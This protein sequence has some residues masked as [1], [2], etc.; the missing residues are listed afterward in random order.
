MLDVF[1]GNMLDR[2][3]DFQHAVVFGQPEACESHRSACCV[4]SL[5]RRAVRDQ[6]VQAYRRLY[7]DMAQSSLDVIVHR[8][9]LD[10]GGSGSCY[11]LSFVLA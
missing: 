11:V 1:T 3:G 4:R 6:Q 5:N 8:C 9:V 10:S 7:D 2:H